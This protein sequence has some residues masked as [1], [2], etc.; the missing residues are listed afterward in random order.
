VRSTRA[1][2]DSSDAPSLIEPGLVAVPDNGS[3]QARAGTQS[4]QVARQA[5]ARGS[6]VLTD[7]PFWMHPSGSH[8]LPSATKI[9]VTLRLINKAFFRI[10]LRAASVSFVRLAQKFKMRPNAGLLTF[11]QIIHAAIASIRDT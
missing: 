10:N 8:Q 2:A 5:G 4:T 9:G 6:D 1:A 11:D 7:Q 3:T